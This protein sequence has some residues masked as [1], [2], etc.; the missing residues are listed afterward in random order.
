MGEVVNLREFRK[1]RKR[2]KKRE[3]AAS[4]RALSGQKKQDRIRLAQEKDNAEQSH[5]A[6]RLERDGD[7][8]A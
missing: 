6:H 5:A 2:D 4:K 7:E 3:E 1:R 8:S